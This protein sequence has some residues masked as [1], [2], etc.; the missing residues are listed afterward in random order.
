MSKKNQNI[1]WDEI[2]FQLV[3]LFVESQKLMI[4]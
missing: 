4:W 2:S 3:E 1:A